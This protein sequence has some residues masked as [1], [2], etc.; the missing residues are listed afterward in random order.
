ML[1]ATTAMTHA[2]SGRGPDGYAHLVDDVTEAGLTQAQIATAVK[3]SVRTVQNWRNGDSTPTG[4][5][6]RRLIDLKYIVEGLREVYTAEGID[7]WLN[8]RNRNLESQRPIDLLASG[9]IDCVSDEIR[10]VIGGM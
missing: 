5:R 2:A 10:R 3:V 8:S 1:N 6:A 9:E 7:I 4:L